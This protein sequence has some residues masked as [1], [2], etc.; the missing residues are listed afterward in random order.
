MSNNY[1]DQLGNIGNNGLY[2]IPLFDLSGIFKLFFFVL[3]VCYLV[4][5][6]L[7][8]LRVRILSETL[9]TPFNRYMG[10]MTFVHTVVGFGVGLLTLVIIL[11]S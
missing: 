10:I 2:T 3:I 1:L 7:M 8:A 6:V 5:L 4:Y 11:L 9:H